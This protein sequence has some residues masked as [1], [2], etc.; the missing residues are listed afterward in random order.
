[1]SHRCG[2]SS[3]CTSAMY[4]FCPNRPR[5]QAAK[6]HA[7]TGCSKATI[8]R[9]QQKGA[10]AK[11]WGTEIQSIPGGGRAESRY[12]AGRAEC[13]LETFMAREGSV[14]TITSCTCRHAYRGP[15]FACNVPSSFDSSCAVAAVVPSCLCF[16]SF[17]RV[18]GTSLLYRLAPG[19]SPTLAGRQ[20]RHGF[21]R[22]RP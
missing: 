4:P 11:A 2:C 6:R 19:H 18:L 14:C 5:Q 12:W 9:C 20:A 1:M 22:M 7:S 15:M 21:R 17:R 8:R 16:F 3:L 10:V 13:G